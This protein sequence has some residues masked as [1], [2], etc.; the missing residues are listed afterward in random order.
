MTAI[1]K[2]IKRWTKG[3]TLVELLVVVAILGILA[4]I[5]ILAIN[6]AEAN[7]KTRDS[8]RLNDAATIRNAMD[9]SIV[10]GE[11]LIV[12]AAPRD[13]ADAGGTDSTVNTNYVGMDVSQFLAVLPTDPMQ[14]EIDV[15]FAAGATCTTATKI[16]RDNPVYTVDSDGSGYEINVGLESLDNCDYL[17]D[18]GGNDDNFFEGGTDPGLDLL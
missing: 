12:F 9:L 4:A 7:R 11:P 6:P 17:N 13:S 18:D 3:F 16:E 10:N 15:L 2:Q 8:A 1:K 5:L 14:T